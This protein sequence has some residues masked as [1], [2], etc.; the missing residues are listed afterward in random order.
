[1]EQILVFCRPGFETE[2]G[3]EMTDSA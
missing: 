3:R 1:M 2:A